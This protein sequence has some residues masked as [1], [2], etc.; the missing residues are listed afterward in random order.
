M[1]IGGEFVQCTLTVLEDMNLDIIM[2]LDLLRKNAVTIDLGADCLRIHDKA[3]R[4]LA[5]KDIPRHMLTL[6]EAVK[7]EGKNIAGR[8]VE[9]E[10]AFM[11]TYAVDFGVVFVQH[12]QTFLRLKLIGRR[13]DQAVQR[14]RLQQQQ[15]LLR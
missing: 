6:S 5:E 10:S 11:E 12:C 7:K 2:G 1:N 14:C 3:I 8:T 15:Q 13:T 9:N 4:F